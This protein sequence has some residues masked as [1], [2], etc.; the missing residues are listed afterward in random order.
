MP[1]FA[2]DIDPRELRQTL[3]AFAAIVP[4]D[5]WK[6]RVRGLSAQLSQN[7]L[8]EGFFLDRYGVELALPEIRQYLATTGR[9]RW[10]PVTVQQHQLSTFMAVVTRVYANLSSAGKARLAGSIRSALQ[11]EAGLG[12]LILEMRVIAILMSSGFDVVFNDLENGGGFDFLAHREG[13]QI[14]VECKHLSADIGRKIHRSKVYDLG[15]ILQPVLS[16]AIDGSTVGRL[17]CVRLPNRLDGNKAQQE[18]I[19]ECVRAILAGLP[20]SHASVCSIS[21]QQFAI[22]DTVFGA[23]TRAGVTMNDVERYVRNVFGLE[24][25]HLLVNWKPGRAAVL[26][27]IESQQPDRVLPKILKTLKESARDQFSAS[28]PA[29]MCIHLADL[30]PRELEELARAD[31]AG[32]ITGIRYAV[33]SL[34]NSRAHLYGVALMTRGDVFL[35]TLNKRL[36]SVQESGPSYVFRKPEHPEAGNPHFARIFNGTGERGASAGIRS[37]R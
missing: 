31:H 5:L 28:R 27:H 3:E 36:R 4:W 22:E 10:P 37:S 18:A 1:R 6:H 14:E 8:W 16:A 35:R 24:Q 7:P 12:P 15:G 19:A 21:V 9:L 33:S 32:E 2:T 11:M 26:V 17:V 34:L 23:E 30:A 13:S 29:F 25:V 20:V